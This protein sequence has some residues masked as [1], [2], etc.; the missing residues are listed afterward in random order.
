[1]HLPTSQDLRERRNELE[2]TQ[3]ELASRADVSQPLIARIEGGDVDP[4][5]STL[6]RIVEA[7]D[8]AEG[9][10]VRARDVMNTDVVNIRPDESVGAASDLMLDEGYSQIPVIRDER[11]EGILT[12]S[13]IRHKRE[14]TPEDI[15]VGDL[16]VDE[17]A[18]EGFD[19]AEPDTPMEQI[20]SYLDRNRAVIVVED[21]KVVGIITEADVAAHI[22]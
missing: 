16:P 7:L 20:D 2:L 17:V 15:E 6:R 9:D 5:L 13:D 14:E 11:P 18:G 1:M 12:N 19:T 10:V 4:R 8:E 3:S 21:G 22:S